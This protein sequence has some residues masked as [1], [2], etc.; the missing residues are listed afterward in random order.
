M[1]NGLGKSAKVLNDKQVAAL[2]R[3]VESDTRRPV[4]NRVVVLLSY[5]AGFRA[6]EI[7]ML[8]WSMVTDT[9]GALIDSISLPN[10]ASKGKRGG[11]VLPMHSDLRIAL[12][13]LYEEESAKGRRTP[14]GFVVVLKQGSTDAITRA[15]SVVFLFKSWYAS[16]GFDGA[17]SHSGRRT[18]ITKA[19]RK[20][21][22]VGGSLRDVQSLAGHA[23]IAITQRYVDTD[24]EA[25]RKLIDRL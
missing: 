20:V 14:D 10:T 12:E 3:F 6:K 23:S 22:E 9:E 13:A 18:F 5:K 4:R 11:R 24:P 19:A 16:L 2:L 8:R 15:N 1:T 21:S 7:A 25:Q 17:S